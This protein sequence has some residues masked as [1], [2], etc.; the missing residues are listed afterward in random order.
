MHKGIGI[1]EPVR[2]CCS[3]WEHRMSVVIQ[4]RRLHAPVFHKQTCMSFPYEDLDLR[5]LIL[6]REERHN[7]Y[8]SAPV[9]D[10]EGPDA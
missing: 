2:S 5:T 9:P 1:A 6:K 4:L 7:R 8:Y 3:F 10:L